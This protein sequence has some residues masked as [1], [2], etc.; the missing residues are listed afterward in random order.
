MT[1]KEVDAGSVR[2]RMDLDLLHKITEELCV[3]GPDTLMDQPFSYLTAAST[4][5]TLQLR[6]NLWQQMSKNIENP[7]EKGKLRVSFKA[8]SAGT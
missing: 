3:L 6:W 2:L 1:R 8:G 7:E 5:R 4:A